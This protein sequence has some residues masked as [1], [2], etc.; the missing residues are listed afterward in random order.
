MR[1]H[2]LSLA[3]GLPTADATVP[4]RGLVRRP[5]DARRGRALTGAAGCAGHAAPWLGS[6]QANGPP[7]NLQDRTRKL[8]MVALGA[9][10]GLLEGQVHWDRR[11]RPFSVSSGTPRGRRRTQ[12]LD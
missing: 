6:D 5:S 9:A 10:R 7:R 1:F 2:E 4:D 12:A 3:D 8:R 11:E